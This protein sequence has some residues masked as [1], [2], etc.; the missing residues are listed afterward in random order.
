MSGTIGNLPASSSDGVILNGS[1]NLTSLSLKVLSG[2]AGDRGQVVVKDGLATR[3]DQF[4]DTYLNKTG[5]LEL[6]ANQLN[7]EVTKLSKVQERIDLRSTTLE[8]RYKRQFTA[9]DLLLAQLQGTSKSIAQQLD[10]LPR[11]NK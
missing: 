7:K 5:D 3:M 4:L 11:M 8:Q 1:G 6:R 10:S 2:S 9:L